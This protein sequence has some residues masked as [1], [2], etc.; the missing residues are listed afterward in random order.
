M[1]VSTICITP[2][3]LLINWLEESLMQVDIWY[4]EEYFGKDRQN[5][6]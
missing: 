2:P 6:D 3:K 1:I 5:I 4:S